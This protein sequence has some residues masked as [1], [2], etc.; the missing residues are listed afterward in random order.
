MNVIRKKYTLKIIRS[1]SNGMSNS[2]T[3]GREGLRYELNSGKFRELSKIWIKI[4]NYIL[5]KKQ[6]LLGQNNLY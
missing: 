5:K 6:I 3:Q 1:S 2:V 4:T